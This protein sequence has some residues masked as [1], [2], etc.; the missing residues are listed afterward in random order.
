MILKSCLGLLQPVANHGSNANERYPSQGQR[1]LM[2]A[3][4]SLYSRPAPEGDG[5]GAGKEE[6]EAEEEKEEGGQGPK[7][8][9]NPP[10]DL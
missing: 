7:R 4:M 10:T 9:R 8:R 6:E 3:L 2:A 1:V 5:K